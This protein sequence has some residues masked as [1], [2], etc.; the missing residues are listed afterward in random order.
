MADGCN[1]YFTEKDLADVEKSIDNKKVI[2]EGKFAANALDCLVKN[3]HSDFLKVLEN[4]SDPRHE[5]ICKLAL[6]SFGKG[7]VDVLEEA[8]IPIALKTV[9]KFTPHTTGLFSSPNKAHG[10]GAS[11]VLHPY[12]VLTAAAIVQQKTIYSK[13]GKALHLYSDDKIF[14]GH[15]SAA[16]HAQSKRY[17]T[18]ESDVLI[19]RADKSVAPTGIDAKYARNGVYDF[20]SERQLTGIRNSIND[21]QLKEF[22]FAT[23]GQFGGKFQDRVS[24]YNVML[25]KDWVKDNKEYHSIKDTSKEYIEKNYHQLVKDY[26]IPQ[27]N[28]CEN[29]SFKT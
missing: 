28:M 22:F 25:T 9:L 26:H 10:P 6:E 17:G 12:E 24:D 23:N 27:I 2:D 14:L 15:K 20:I 7:K 11:R 5:S 13:N 18:I 16:N 19:Q 29:V 3:N 8:K 4:K 21:G 1:L